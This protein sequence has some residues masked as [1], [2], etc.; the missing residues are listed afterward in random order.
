MVV[1]LL[2]SLGNAGGHDSIG[3]KLKSYAAITCG[4]VN[5]VGFLGCFCKEDLE[6]NL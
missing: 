1:R 4:L 6:E 3:I 2:V 5:G